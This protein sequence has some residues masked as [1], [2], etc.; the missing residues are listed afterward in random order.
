MKPTNNHEL[1]QEMRIAVL[2]WGSLIS[3]PDNLNFEGEWQS[4]GPILPIE[5]SR[6]S[7]DGRLTLVIDT[8]KGKK[9]STQFVVSRFNDLPQAIENLRVREGTSTQNIGFVNLR[10]NTYR[11]RT[12]TF[13]A[14]K[15]W[16]KEYKFDAVIWT[17]LPPS[18]PKQPF[19]VLRAIKYLKSLNPEEAGT[20]R[21]YIRQAPIDVMT[22]LRIKLLEDGWL[23]EGSK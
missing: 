12:N 3:K 17:D 11:S 22:P 4:K 9:L 10:N 5:F 16:A 15:K 13:R 6:R 14:I 20:A 2:G 18:F 23:N 19:T 7:R 21:Q 1:Q 8:S